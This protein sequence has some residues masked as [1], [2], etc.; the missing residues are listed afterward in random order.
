MSIDPSSLMQNEANSARARWDN[1][2]LF[3]AGTG[4]IGKLVT[5]RL[6]GRGAW[7]QSVECALS[8]NRAS[9]ADSA[10]GARKAQNE[11]KI[12]LLLVVLQHS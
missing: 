11:A 12:I 8:E 2:T 3:A 4:T 1:G 10:R 5:V 9:A 6:S 7:R